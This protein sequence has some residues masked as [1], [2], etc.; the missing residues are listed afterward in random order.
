MC[1]KKILV[2][3]SQTV[4]YILVI[5]VSSN[6]FS[7]TKQH[8]HFGSVCKIVHNHFFCC[9]WRLNTEQLN[10]VKPFCGIHWKRQQKTL[11]FDKIWKRNKTEKI[12]FEIYCSKTVEE[13]ARTVHLFSECVFFLFLSVQINHRA[14]AWKTTTDSC[15]VTLNRAIRCCGDTFK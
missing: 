15:I 14:A 8:C 11:K 10:S 5:Y 3:I 6:R 4:L 9:C 7:K 12:F 2:E 1:I 13:C